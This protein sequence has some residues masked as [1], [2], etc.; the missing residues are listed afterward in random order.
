MEKEIVFNQEE[1]GL[2]IYINHDENKEGGYHFQVIA[3]EPDGNI[4][5]YGWC[6]HRSTAR[7]IIHWLY[8]G[9]ISS[10]YLPTYEDFIESKPNLG[11]N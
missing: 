4:V 5:D 6:D 2:D 9:I 3:E 1:H 7:R 8:G 11:I 10:G